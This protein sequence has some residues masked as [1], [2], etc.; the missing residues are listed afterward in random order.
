MSDHS[1]LRTLG[2]TGVRVSPLTLGTMMFGAWGNPDHDES[3]R[4]IHRALDAGINV[5]DT[6]DVYARGESEEIVGKAL[7]GRRDEVVL[8]TKF[9]GA[10]S[11]DDPN[12]GGNSRRWIV[13]AV[14][15]SLRRLGT[16]HLDLYQ[17]HR[18]RPE[19]DLDETLGALSD[20]V[21]QGKIRYVGTSTFLASQIVE[22]QWVAERRHRERPV[23]EQPPYSIL[24][25]AVERDV[26]PTAQK[27]GLGVLPWSPLAGG[28]LSG[29]YRRDGDTPV[30]S[31]QQRQPARHD[32][33]SPENRG[34]A[35]EGVRAD[36]PGRPGRAVADPPGAGVRAGAPGGVVGDHRPA[37]HG[38]ARVPARRREGVAV[39]GRARP[40]RRDRRAGHDAQ[41][42]R[43]GLRAPGADRRPPAQ[44]GLGRARAQGQL[45]SA[46]SARSVPRR[47]RIPASRKPSRS[48]SNT[49]VGLPTS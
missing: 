19:T 43:P 45:A 41:R 13:R 44:T 39:A 9:H 21:H 7:K 26:L 40:D 46:A 36:R 5:L 38:A 22:A 2:T 33:R 6:A 31:R 24:A 4:I 48:P 25:R 49:A 11:D 15:D 10:M 18:P 8:A 29:R 42:G 3:V 23:T 28:W 37:D 35:R 27:Y 17:V 30:S 16:D 32:P 34:Q 12:M 1:H 20:L 47:Q 14:E